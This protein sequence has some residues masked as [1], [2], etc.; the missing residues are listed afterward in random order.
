MKNIGLIGIILIITVF[1]LVDLY[2]YKGLKDI[3]KGFAQSGAKKVFFTSYWIINITLYS[4]WVFIIIKSKEPG[5]EVPFKFVFFSFG[6]FL[7]FFIPKLIFISFV[8]IN[9]ISNFVMSFFKPSQQQVAGELIGRSLFITYLGAIIASIPLFSLGWGML[10]GRYKF[11]VYEKELSFSSLP[12][13]FDG[14]RIIQISD[15]HIGSFFKEFDKVERGLQMI[16]DLKPDMIL[17]TGDMVNNTAEEA[18]PWIEKLQSI[19]APMGK[20]SVLGNHDYG[21]YVDWN[22]TEAKKANLDKLISI[23]KKMGFD[24][25][26]NENRTIEKNGDRFTLAGVEN[27][28]LPPFP[29]H[30]NLK[31]ALSGSVDSDFQLLMS[32]DPSHWDAEIIKESKVDLTLAGHTHGMQF[33]IELGNIKWSPVKYKYPRWAGLYENEK[34]KLYVNRGFGYI[35]YPGRV[36]IMPEITLI[37]LKK[38]V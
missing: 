25:L 6:I 31:Q 34:Q 8:L 37:T 15:L 35:G 18:L 22:S 27:W 19:N 2:S 5:V 17:F 38:K 10:I 30:G 16:R 12:Q 21:D 3:V 4:I 33:G 9:D 7:M 23:H 20:F 14:L 29:Q 11:K 28:G 13:A 36:G 1:F 26:L 32:H 24:I